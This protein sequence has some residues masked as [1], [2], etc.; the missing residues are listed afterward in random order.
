MHL[1]FYKRY[2]DAKEVNIEQIINW[3]LGEEN[4]DFET[5]ENDD[6]YSLLEKDGEIYELGRGSTAR[7]FVV[8][9]QHCNS[10]FNDRVIK[11]F[12]PSINGRPLLNERCQY[13]S[14]SSDK[15]IFRQRL[16]KFVKSYDQAI[17]VK[18]SY[19]S[20]NGTQVL[21]AE[22]YL[23][24]IGLCYVTPYVG[25]ILLKDYLEHDSCINES[26][27][28]VRETSKEI[29]KHFKRGLFH[30]DIKPSNLWLL[31]Y[32]GAKKIEECS[33]RSLDFGS[34]FNIDELIL[35]IEEILK[36]KK[37][38]LT[39]LGKIELNN[40]VSSLFKFSF[41]S[42]QKYYSHETIKFLIG[43]LIKAISEQDDKAIKMIKKRFLLLDIVAMMRFIVFDVWKLSW[44]DDIDPSKFESFE[45]DM[46]IKQRITTEE[47][48]VRLHM[49]KG[50]FSDYHK[51]YLLVLLFGWCVDIEALP[52]IDILSDKTDNIKWK[53]EAINNLLA[54]D[55]MVDELL[56]VFDPKVGDFS[57]IDNHHNIA[58][59]DFLL[60]QSELLTVDNMIDY[61]FDEF[62]R[63]VPP[64]DII[65]K[66]YY[67]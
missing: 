17:A 15:D 52:Q 25:G 56:E 38:S 43:E 34:C 47:E 42:T 23:T 1:T 66:L 5:S 27:I 29:L 63:I 12:F 59:F 18:E 20:A 33:I 32:S 37:I 16:I 57:Y 21:E 7:A 62:G 50:S 49:K 41:E 40:I 46:L 11:Q 24:S 51:A 10:K 44:P 4:C 26:L 48:I 35:E 65:S 45:R 53:Q 8:R 58:D 3:Y 13:F 22:L 54:I 14:D 39:Q 31:D 60:L 28:I 9:G 30:G 61:V 64:I 2:K 55:S 19:K 36:E 6:T 67:E